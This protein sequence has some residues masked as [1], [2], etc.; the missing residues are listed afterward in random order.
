MSD[1]YPAGVSNSHPHFNENTITAEVRCEREEADVVPSFAITTALDE[2]ITML[3]YKPYAPT[4]KGV[5]LQKAIVLRQQITD[6]EQNREYEC[7]FDGEVEVEVRDDAEWTC[8]LC[9]ATH[10]INSLPEGPD[11]DRAWDER[12]GN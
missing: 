12:H 2:L 10:E 4:Q 5:I 6:L 8:P 11:P 9:G 3:E 7:P 1:N